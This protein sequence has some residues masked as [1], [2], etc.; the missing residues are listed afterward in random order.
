MAQVLVLMS[1]PRKHGNTDRLANALQNM[2]FDAQLEYISPKGVEENGYSTEKIYVNYQNIK[3]CLGCNVCQKTNQCVQKDDMQDIYKKML[4]AK[5]IVFASPVYFYTFNASMKLLLDRTFAIEK[6][7]HDKD[8]YLLSTG[9][10]P[11]E[12]YFRII[13]ETFQKYIDCLRVGGNRFVDS[14]LGFQTGDKDDI[15]KIDSIEKAYNMAKEI[16]IN[17]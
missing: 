13:K 17:E 5:V 10:A 16:K 12:S 7:I 14:I 2:E 11:D 1:S 15:E 6:T 9:L 4:E 3:P 8:F